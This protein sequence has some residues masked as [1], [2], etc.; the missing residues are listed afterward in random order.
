MRKNTRSE[1][2]TVSIPFHFHALG[3]AAAVA[4][5]V[6]PNAAFSPRLA[7]IGDD[8]DEYRVTKL[9][10]RILPGGAASAA[11]SAACYQPGIVDTPPATALTISES[12]NT[13][14][15]GGGQTVPTKWS[16]VPAGVL[17]GMHPWYKTVPGTPE[18]SEELQGGI[19][20]FL[21][22]TGGVL[23]WQGVCE[24]RAAIA[25]GNTPL[26]RALAARRREKKRITSLLAF[27]DSLPTSRVGK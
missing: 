23:E 19:Y 25:A 3:A 14:L 8:F 18:A 12:I 11:T 26:E 5:S 24:F 9:Q 21:A 6:S 15:L 22:V 27:D 17:A 2:D 13:T 16:S 7:A 4:V 1:R 10:F 20:A